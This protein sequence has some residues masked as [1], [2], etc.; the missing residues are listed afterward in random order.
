MPMN[1]D[2]TAT[3]NM[4]LRLTT[5]KPCMYHDPEADADILFELLW[6]TLACFKCRSGAVSGTLRLYTLNEVLAYQYGEQL[7][8]DVAAAEA[9]KAQAIE[10][11]K[12]PVKVLAAR[13]KAHDWY[14]HFS[15]SSAVQTVGRADRAAI[16][17][18]LEKR[19]LEQAQQLWLEHAPDGVAFPLLG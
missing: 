15:D 14:F 12:D 8:L 6:D 10:D 2:N 1:A 4:A 5:D 11:A 7:R 13:L 9:A 17:R 16:I 3:L 19:P 18:L